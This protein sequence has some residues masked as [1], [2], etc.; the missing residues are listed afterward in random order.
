MG[1]ASPI[2]HQQ[3]QSLTDMA[4]GQSDGAVALLRLPVVPVCRRQ[5]DRIPGGSRLAKLAKSGLSERP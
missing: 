4:A 2:S 3:G 5:R 1:W